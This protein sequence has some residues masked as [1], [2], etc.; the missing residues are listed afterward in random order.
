MTL[1]Q[2]PKIRQEQT[3]VA[4]A[5]ASLAEVTLV[6]ATPAAASPGEVIRVV[7][8]PAVGEV[9]LDGQTMGDRTVRITKKFSS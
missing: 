3:V 6:E 8:I 4:A 7:A 5:A 2:G 9:P 1:A